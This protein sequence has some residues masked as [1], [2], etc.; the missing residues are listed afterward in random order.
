MILFQLV[1]LNVGDASENCDGGF[2]VIFSECFSFR[3]LF[4]K[5]FAFFI[6]GRSTCCDPD[7]VNSIMLPSSARRASSR[8]A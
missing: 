8:E 4:E 2:N 7:I 3:R 6:N 1:D 5:K